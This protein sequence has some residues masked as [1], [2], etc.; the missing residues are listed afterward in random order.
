MRITDGGRNVRKPRQGS[1]SGI[2][3]VIARGAGRQV[4][5]EDDDDRC[6]YLNDL[7]RFAISKDIQ[8]IAWCL[9]DNHVHLLLEGE[10]DAVSRFMQTLSSEY[11]QYFNGRHDRVG[12]LF[13]SRYKSEPVETDEYFLT[14]ICYIH[15]NPERAGIAPADEYRWSSFSEYAEA[16]VCCRTEKA[17]QI[18][19]SREQFLML[20]KDESSVPSATVMEDKS[21]SKL[22]SDDL[23]EYAIGLLGEE[24]FRRLKGLPKEQRDRAIGILRANGMSVRQIE[25]ITGIGRGII[26][27]VKWSET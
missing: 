2:Y 23:V 12:P 15:N 3:H 20:H 6:R 9:M 16:P 1:E 22:G 8:I 13:Q 5:F 27:R 19:G 24:V 7:E 11:A 21:F 18:I 10:L 4:I 25:R 17:L 14:V 26:G